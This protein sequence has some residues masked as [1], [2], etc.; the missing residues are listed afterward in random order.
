MTEEVK[1][2]PVQE[3]AIAQTPETVQP[4]TE[5]IEQLNWKRFRQEREEE[6]KAKAAAE[7]LAR[8]KHEENLALQQALAAAV[9]K[10]SRVVPDEPQDLDEDQKIELKVQ[11]ALRKREL[12]WEKERAEK[13][14]QELPQRLVANFKDFNQVC[15]TENLDYLEYHYPEVAGP[16]KHMPDGYQ[17][18]EGIYKALKRFIPVKESNKE[19]QR[20]EANLSKPGA[21]SKPGMTQTGDH[22]PVMMDDAKRA[23]NW[24]RMQKVIKGI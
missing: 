5:T 20:A 11:E 14:Q 16:Y 15:T 22:A 1:V 7:E 2:E 18:W 9:S 3:Q 13:E 19:G 17:K 10:P 24:A 12:Q 23:A 8:K 4:P 6:R 21:L